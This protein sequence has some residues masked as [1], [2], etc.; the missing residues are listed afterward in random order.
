MLIFLLTLLLTNA[1]VKKELFLQLFAPNV[2]IT[3]QLVLK[4]TIFHLQTCCCAENYMFFC[5]YCSR[6]KH[7]LNYK[8]KKACILVDD[9]KKI[10]FDIHPIDHYLH[11]KIKASP[12]SYFDRIKN[13][14]IIRLDSIQYGNFFVS[15]DTADF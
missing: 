10:P 5:S 11:K 15:R 3:F 2:N 14:V 12:L 13:E 9:V 8:V 7:Y 4:E 1:F 6:L